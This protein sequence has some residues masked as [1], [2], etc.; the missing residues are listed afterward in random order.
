MPRSRLAKISLYACGGLL[1]LLAVAVLAASVILQG[2][3]LGSLVQGALPHNRGKLEIGGIG[4]SLRA[5]ADLATDAPSPIS[6]DGLRI[7][8]PEGTVV[9]DVPHLT[10]RVKLRTLI[11]GSFS[12]HDLR[13]P[14]ATWR[15]AEMK[16]EPLIGFL[17]ALAPQTPPPAP[18]ANT[19]PA[20][21]SFFQIVGAQLDDLNALFDFPGSWGLELRHARATASLMQST[22]D[23][24]HPI[25]G[26]DAAPV[27][28]EGGG[29]L[30]IL[31]DNQL[32]F[33]KV[34][35]NRVATTQDRPDDIFLDLAAANTGRSTLTGKG[36]FT[37]IYGETSIPGIALRADFTLP[38]DALTAVAAGKGIEG[39]TVGGEGAASHIGLDL[40]DTFARLKV[41]AKV[42]GLDVTFDQDGAQYRALDTGLDLSF[43]AGADRV[44]VSNFG[45]RA[46]DGGRLALNARLATDTLKLDADL[47][48]H[49][50]RTESYLPAALRAMGGGAINGKVVARGDLA[51]KA[52]TVSAL[53]LT[54][55][56]TRAAGLPR[57]VR[58]HGNARVS[59]EEART[60]GLTVE[61]PGATATAKGSLELERKL[62]QLGLDVVAFDLGRVLESLGLP[63][64]AKDARLSAAASGTLDQPAV[65][66]DAVVHGVGRGAR[67][68][69][70]LKARFGLR[71]GR[72]RLE[73]LSGGLFGGTLAASG[74]I[75]LFKKNTR[76]PLRTP[77]IDAQL[78][79]RDVDLAQVTG[80]SD[81]VGRVSADVKARGPLDAISADVHVPA[82]TDVQFQGTPFRVG[83][84]DA[85]LVANVATVR[86]LHV[87]LKT[88]G[89]LD[90]TG[91][92]ALAPARA[93][94]QEKNALNVDVVLAK[95]PLAALPGVADAGVPLTGTVS[96][97][98]HVGGTIDHPAIGGTVDLVEVIARGVALGTGHL[99]LAPV[100]DKAGPGVRIDGSLFDRFG[101]HARVALDKDGP[102]V[103]GAVDFQRLALETLVPELAGFGDARGVATGHV[104]VDID[105]GQPLAVDALLPEL[106]L[107]IARAVDGSD[108]ETSFQRVRIQTA[109]PLHLEV[110]GDQVVLDEARFQTDGGELRAQG[111]LDGQRISGD[112]SGHLDLELLQP[113]LRGSVDKISG[114]LKVALSAR[115]TRVAPQLSGQIDVVSPVKLRPKDVDADIALASGHFQLN[116]DQVKVQDVLLTVE[117]ST[118]RLTGSAAL[119][120]SFQPHDIAVDLDGEINARLLTFAA[121]QAVTDAHGKARI[122]GQMRG[123][124]TKPQIFGS[125][126]LGAITFRLRDT[127]TEV[128]VQSGAVELNNAGAVLHDVRVRL[129]DQGLLIIGASG[130][131]AGRVNFTNLI[132][133]EPGDVDLPLHG[134]QLSYRIPNTAEIDDLAFD[135]N[136]RGN[137]HEGFTLGGEVRLVSGRYLQ[138]FKV[139]SLVISP[140]V[141]ETD[142]RPFYE[143]K[144]LLEGLSLDLGVRTIGEG[145]VVQNN[146]APEIHIDVALHIGG[147]LAE[148]ALAGTVRPT[149]GRFSFPGFRGEFEL[150]PNASYATFVETKSL[151]YGDTPDLNIEAQNPVVDASG[152]E[153]NVRMHIHGPLREAQIDLTT[154]DGLDRNQTALLLLTGRT[155][156]DSQRIS[157]QNPTVGANISTGADV[158]G[159]LT[160]DT[161][162]N[163]MEPYIDNTFQR[164]TGLDLRLTVGPDGFEGR[165]RKR[166]SRKVNFQADTLFG[167]QGQ[168]RKSAQLNFWIVDYV[169]VAGTL[170]W[171]TLSSQQGVNETLP[172]NGSFELRWDFPIRR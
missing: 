135:L 160:R 171:L 22:V 124:L 91:T 112:V 81:V 85:Q 71:D 73:S 51:R 147:T 103:H 42:G 113:F 29:W 139:Q 36:Y 167:F 93:K 1:G 60:S 2:P 61:I 119:G 47:V 21:G 146:I 101:V 140:R 16:N 6:L 26:F 172:P 96:A 165:V 82:G 28:A 99:T 153:H 43:D 74:Q 52:V 4:W 90:V 107:S 30:R 170:E 89:S 68:V 44:A 19:P 38:G 24:A 162:A 65:T 150:V 39:L 102:S 78:A 128:A 46:P 14:K 35:I 120:P 159:Q 127:G 155:T 86:A 56:R 48:L 72:G 95:V 122:K 142:V 133:F 57:T 50:F 76:H 54:L 108:G 134:E 130:V 66:G 145:F 49:D 151:T 63:R 41:A 169:S 77:V 116:G 106:W 156:T 34:T 158:A 163:L 138:D 13:V 70:E 5:L 53:D 104:S 83:P 15:F 64:W 157:T 166:I 129:D 23:P 109:Q 94:R 137:V 149:D 126:E 32:P 92:V 168:S 118:V 55:A 17:A 79:A 141:D 9:L 143:G 59:P 84:I 20:P 115:G 62:V 148:P 98:L 105:P 97:R 58:I 87:A 117:G 136:L 31:E 8:D 45:L 80:R 144:P 27:V 3:R 12:I 37:G 67:T 75:E 11:G 25:F 154:D 123:S 152:N 121:P 40:K 110:K 125:L 33:D 18:P 114:D 7:I 161:I 10:A 131:R 88:G 132:P 100:D 164:L 69:P 111:R